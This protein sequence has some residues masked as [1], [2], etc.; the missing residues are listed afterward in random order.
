[1]YDKVRRPSLDKFLAVFGIGH[2]YDFKTGY[3]V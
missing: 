1:V 3:L 2:S